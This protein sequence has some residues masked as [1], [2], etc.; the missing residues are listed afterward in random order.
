MGSPFACFPLKLQSGL[1]WLLL[2]GSS[3]ALSCLS[4]LTHS[5]WNYYHILLWGGWAGGYHL[6]GL[7]VEVEEKV[8]AEVAVAVGVGVGVADKVAVA[9]E[10]EVEAEHEVESEVAV[11]V[12]VGVGAEV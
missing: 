7:E 2:T 10:V 8:D 6:A 4:R 12:G 9:V 3:H 5:G 11:G 1:A